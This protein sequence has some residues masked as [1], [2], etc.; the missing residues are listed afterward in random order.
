MLRIG[1]QR[2]GRSA[3]A[4]YQLVLMQAHHG[5]FYALQNLPVLSDVTSREA[6]LAVLCLTVYSVAVETRFVLYELDAVVQPQRPSLY[7][8]VEVVLIVV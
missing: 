2:S 7:S 1:L 8:V 4:E 6:E 5:H 3:V